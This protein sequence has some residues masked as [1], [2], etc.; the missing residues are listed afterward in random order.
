MLVT[1]APYTIKGATF[2]CL[3]DVILERGVSRERIRRTIRKKGENL[4]GL[5]G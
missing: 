2:D 3:G 4:G 1:A 5:I